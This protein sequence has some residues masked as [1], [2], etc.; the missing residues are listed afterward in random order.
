MSVATEQLSLFEIETVATPIETTSTDGIA[1]IY[2]C[3]Q[4]GKT[5]KIR[6]IVRY[7]DAPVICSD[8]STKGV[9]HGSRWHLMFTS[10]SNYL[11]CHGGKAVIDIED[12]GRFQPLLDSLNITPI[13]ASDP[14]IASFVKAV[15]Q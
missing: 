11:K 1:L 13:S 5:S 7:E 8:A 10:L 4:S 2:S 3:A 9:S 6:L 12:D 15:G 14:L